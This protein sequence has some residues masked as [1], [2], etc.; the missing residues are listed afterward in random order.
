[1]LDYKIIHIHVENL[2]STLKNIF[3]KSALK[4]STFP[5][6]PSSAHPC[7]VAHGCTEFT[8]QEGT[9]AKKQVTPGI[10][11]LAISFPFNNR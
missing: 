2:C 3:K 1:L 11:I 7:K 10:C 5:S 4:V 9:Q 8:L 6:C